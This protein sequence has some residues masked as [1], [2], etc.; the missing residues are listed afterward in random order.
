MAIKLRVQF[1]YDGDKEWDLSEFVHLAE[2]A[3]ATLTGYP[4]LTDFDTTVEEI[5]FLEMEEGNESGSKDFVVE[6]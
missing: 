4:Y 3:L 1:H 5:P 2:E 6:E